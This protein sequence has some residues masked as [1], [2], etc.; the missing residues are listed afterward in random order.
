MSTRGADGRAPLG[1]LM[2]RSERHLVGSTG[3]GGDPYE[4]GGDVPISTVGQPSPCPITVRVSRTMPVEWID[5]LLLATTDIQPN[6]SIVEAT[7]IVLGAAAEMLGEAAV[8]VCVPHADGQIVVRRSPRPPAPS[9]DPARLFPEFEHERVVALALDGT[10]LHLASD[11]AGRFDA[12]GA[13]E[14]MVNRL[15]LALASTIRHCRAYEQA[16]AQADEMRDL[17]EQMIQSEKLA[18]VGQIAAGIVHELNNPLTSIVAYSDYLTKK[19]ERGGGDPADVERLRR[20]NE[21]AERILRFARDLVAYARPAPEVPAPVALHDVIER[22]LVFCEHVLDRTGVYVERAYGD[23]APVRGVAGQLTQVFVNLFTN[24]AQ[25]M[26]GAGGHIAITTRMA[27]DDVVHVE[28]SD[29]GEGIDAADLTKVFE[30]FYTTK[31]EGSGLGLSI[32]RRIVTSHC[33]RIHAEPRSPR[34]TVFVI[35]L[36]A[37]ADVD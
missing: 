8:G 22:A 15:A 7:G 21:A 1:A 12:G 14:G 28:V 34:G 30:P 27:G 3:D 26:G 4:P 29:D 25:A 35:E 11:D 9:P 17:R 13:A 36:P 31:S 2:G 24:A 6:A 33:G 37:S 18:S 19:A 16:K 20:I 10:T 32:V 5:R 23:V